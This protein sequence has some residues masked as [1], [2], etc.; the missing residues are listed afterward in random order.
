MSLPASRPVWNGMS[1]NNGTDA[2]I[3]NFTYSLAA[4]ANTKIYYLC[5]K[6]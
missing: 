2:V 6:K 3:R 5:T 4:C 1:G